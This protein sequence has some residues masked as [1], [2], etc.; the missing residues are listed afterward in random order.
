MEKPTTEIQLTHPE[1]IPNELQTIAE[2]SGL[3]ITEAQG[4]AIKFAP[5]MATVNEYAQL[6]AKIEKTNPTEVDAKLAREYRLKLVANRGKN[7]MDIVHTECKAGVIVKGKLIDNLYNLVE[8]SSKL[9]ELEAEAIEKHQERLEEKRKTEVA[10]GRIELL[11]PF[12]TDTT[13]LPLNIMT[14]E[15]FDRLLANES[16]LFTTRQEVEAKA[17]RER[18]EAERLAEEKRL[19]DEQKERERLEAERVEAERIRIE[20]ER[21]ENEKKAEIEAAH[22]QAAI[23]IEQLLQDGFTEDEGGDLWSKQGSWTIGYSDLFK[24]TPDEFATTVKR[25]NDWIIER[26]AMEAEEKR[27]AAELKAANDLAEKQRA[28]NA[29]KLAEQQRLAK[30][31]SDKQAKL[32][33]DQKAASDKLAAE[34][35]VKK[36][37]E[38]RIANEK[39]A[40][41]KQALIAPDKDKINALDLAIKNIAIP[42]FKTPEA[43]KIG[44]KVQELLNGVLDEIKEQ[45]KNLK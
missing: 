40:A 19:A 41:E 8:N 36:D 6:I 44:S 13:Y 5:Y 24:S 38:I 23:Y 1:V 22:K 15:Q 32:L 35:K 9:S 12:G 10:A 21:I 45:S 39:I 42:E 33:A 4:I 30:I 17:E 43:K 28:E 14:D 31:E 34:L 25:I 37:E 26:N 20:L 3:V 11:L 7:G 16:L 18:V 29:A 27:H 2:K